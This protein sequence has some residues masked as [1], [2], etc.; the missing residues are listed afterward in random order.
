LWQLAS[1]RVPRIGFAIAKKRIPGAVGRNRLRRLARESFRSHAYE[2]P[3][4]DIVLLAQP[5]AAHANNAELFRSLEKHWRRIGAASNQ[6][7]AK[8]TGNDNTR[9]TDIDG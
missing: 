7:S 6:P 3:S 4:V 2:L 1:Q 8:M 9:G 5:A